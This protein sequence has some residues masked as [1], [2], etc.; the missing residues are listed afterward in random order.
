VKELLAEL[1]PLVT[2]Q[3]FLDIWNE[4]PRPD[5]LWRGSWIRVN[6]A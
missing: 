4:I 2:R 1:E 6:A 3:E 5:P